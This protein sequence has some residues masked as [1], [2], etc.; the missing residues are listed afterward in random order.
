MGSKSIGIITFPIKKNGVMPLSNLVDIISN[1][2]QK[3][4]LV[5]G[6]EGYIHFQND[7]RLTTYN[8]THTGSHSI[9][10]RI[11]RYLVIQLQIAKIIV[12]SRHNVSTWIF[13]IGGSG[14]I[15]P[16][17]AA[18]VVGKKTYLLL[19]G[20]ER[21]GADIAYIHFALP[22]K[23]LISIGYFIVDKIIVYSASLIHTWDLAMYEN[24]ILIAHEHFLDLNHL[25][26]TTPLADRPPLIGYIGSLG[27]VKGVRNFARALPAI[28]NDQRDLRVLI[29]GD[30]DLKEAVEVSLQEGGVTARVDLSGWIPHNELPDYLNRLRL[31]VLP[32]YSEGLPNIVL[33]AMACGTPVLATPVGA[34]SDI[35]IDG[36][37]GF[38]MENN[39]PEYIA[40]SVIRAL[41]SLDLEQIAEG[42]R[43]FVEGNFSF[44]ST[45]VRWEEMLEEI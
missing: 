6:G 28:L 14:L 25:T 23:L 9:L 24:K 33:E 45:I 35:I 32:S 11:Y 36:K 38:I 41:N 44:E 29:G 27:E 34:I 18:K 16:L 7:R 26:V 37:T 8:I 31:L 40:E 5:T 3:T 13:F 10:K 17:I 2:C 19:A 42:G 15:I 21:R 12:V 4:Y 39:S 20:S 1:L 43:R 22:V 30:G